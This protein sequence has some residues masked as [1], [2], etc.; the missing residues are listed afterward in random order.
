M[1]ERRLGLAVWVKNVKTAKNL[2][3][4]GN[5]HFVSRR[6]NYVSMYVAA[7]RIDETIER[8]RRLD[9]VIRV[10]RSH[11][12]EIPREYSNSKPDKAKEYDYKL[13]ET[14]LL[15]NGVLPIASVNDTV[16]AK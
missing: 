8:I 5:I 15:K 2:R 6:L 12:H 1:R 9:F 14:L 7:D 10:E 16:E 13:E 11:R 4:F 3:K